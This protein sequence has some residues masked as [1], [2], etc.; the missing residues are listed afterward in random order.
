MAYKSFGFARLSFSWLTTEQ[1]WGWLRKRSPYNC[2]FHLCGAQRG[3]KK[4]K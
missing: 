2:Q 4:L 1:E 3:A